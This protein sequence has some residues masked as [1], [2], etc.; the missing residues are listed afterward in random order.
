MTV[1]IRNKDVLAGAMFA[2]FGLFGLWIGRD[3]DAGEAGE[4]GAG[5]FPRA[6][7]ILL[8]VLGGALIAVDV[9]RGGAPAERM[10][11]R[12]FACVIASTLAFALLL[13]PL[14]LVATLAIAVTLGSLADRWMG[15]LRLAV[16][17]AALVGI[18]VGVFV[19]AMNIQ[20]PLWPRWG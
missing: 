7:C 16:L 13:R 2:A 5:Y 9:V 14:G 20:I 17:I 12:P 19:L 18:N 11:L 10:A 1:A 15:S 8:V 4:M 3:L 6:I